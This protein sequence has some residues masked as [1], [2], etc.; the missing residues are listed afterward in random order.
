MHGAKQGFCNCWGAPE[1]GA[2]G[3][4]TMETGEALR[5]CR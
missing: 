4:G 5:V 3:E 1:E 2:S